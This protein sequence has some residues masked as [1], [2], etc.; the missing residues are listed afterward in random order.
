M[1]IT[2]D[3]IQSLVDQLTPSD[4]AR[5]AAHLNAQ[6]AQLDAAEQRESMGGA[7]SDAWDRLRAFRQELELLGADAPDFAA[8]LDLDRR[9]RGESLEG[10][11]RVHD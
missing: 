11:G 3:Q 6:L 2:L 7:A 4:K 10:S 1:S 9:T 8:E 5:L